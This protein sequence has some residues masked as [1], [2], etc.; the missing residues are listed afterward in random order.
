MNDHSS[1]ALKKK[2]TTNRIAT[3]QELRYSWF[4]PIQVGKNCTRYLFII[5]W[6]RPGKFVA[7]EASIAY[8]FNT[9]SCCLKE[10]PRPCDY[11]KYNFKN[12]QRNTLQ[13]QKWPQ[14]SKMLIM[15]KSRRR[16]FWCYYYRLNQLSISHWQFLQSLISSFQ[17]NFMICGKRKFCYPLILNASYFDW[18]IGANFRFKD[19]STATH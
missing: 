16:W 4:I 17:M 2:K 11:H 18:R 7:T 8:W 14:R 13:G 5:W 15:D 10:K 3:Y 9:S 19:S 1:W 12:N 6:M